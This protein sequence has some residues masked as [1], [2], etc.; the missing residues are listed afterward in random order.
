MTERI[1]L[2]EP[3]RR[4][5]VRPG[6]VVIQVALGVVLAP[7]E[8]E[9]TAHGT[10]AHGRPGLVADRRGSVHV[11]RHPLHDRTTRVADLRHRSQR[12]LVVVTQTP[13]DGPDE[14][15]KVP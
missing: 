9:W 3:P 14:M 15:G 1:P 5:I 11:V 10:A 8:Q 13:K 7:R 2:Q 4:G 12:L 6:P